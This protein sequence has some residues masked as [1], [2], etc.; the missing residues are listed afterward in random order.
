MHW[1]RQG[2]L[3][4]QGPWFVL[5]GG[6]LYWREGETEQLVV[7]QAL[8]EWVLHLAHDSL[9]VGHQAMQQALVRITQRFYWPG[10]KALVKRY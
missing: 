2:D 10:I 4:G 1:P 7:L 6:L 5:W 8:L 3:V 9:L